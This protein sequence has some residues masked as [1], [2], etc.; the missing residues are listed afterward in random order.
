MDEELDIE[1]TNMHGVGGEHDKFL[2]KQSAQ[3]ERAWAEA[4]IESGVQVWRIEKFRVVGWPRNM[5]GQ[6]HTGD[7]YIILETIQED[8]DLIYNI[9]FW[10]GTESSQ[11]EYA[12]AAYKTVEL[13]SFLDGKAKHCREVQGEETRQFMDIFPNLKYLPGGIESGFRHVLEELH[14]PKLIRIFKQGKIM[15]DEE[16]KMDR[17]SLNQSDCFVLDAGQTIYIWHG[18]DSKPLVKY[19]A[20]SYG[21]RLQSRRGPKAVCTHETGDA[22]WE[23]LGGRGHVHRPSRI[24]ATGIAVTK[25]GVLYLLSDESG[26]LHL[27]EIA[28]D[29]LSLTMLVPEHVMILDL[30]DEINIWIGK[31]SSRSE[32]IN[33]FPTVQG[34]LKDHGRDLY[35]TTHV[36][37]QG[38]KIK[39]ARWHAAFM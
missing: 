26:K 28:R 30:S 20:N 38:Q 19:E 8:R 34:F 2:R 7:S 12:T 33:A 15:E 24:N 25:P 27:S 11:D 23:L 39:N 6:F 35:I 1:E 4:G 36:Y 29:K 9:F 21:E 3:F 10:I 17:S 16:V 14:K 32:K 5:Y 13:D 22:F 37:K 18:A 31:N